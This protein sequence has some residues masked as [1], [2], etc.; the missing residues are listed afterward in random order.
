MDG[1]SGC[2]WHLGARA[3]ASETMASSCILSVCVHILS[4]VLEIRYCVDSSASTDRIAV[5]PFFDILSQPKTNRLNG[6]EKAPFSLV[7]RHRNILCI[8]LSNEK[9]QRELKIDFT[10]T[11]I[12]HIKR[13]SVKLYGMKKTTFITINCVGHCRFNYHYIWHD[14]MAS[15]CFI[16]FCQVFVVKG[17]WWCS[18]TANLK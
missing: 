16:I 12:K 9:Q 13:I 2:R 10:P 11:L 5:A 18:P 15:A 6:A 14:W 4:P 7:G 3:T 17:Q 8:L 1:R